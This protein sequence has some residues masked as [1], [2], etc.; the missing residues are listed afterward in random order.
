MSLLNNTAL[1]LFTGACVLESVYK[2]ISTHCCVT[3]DVLLLRFNDCC[4]ITAV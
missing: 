3:T 2:L 1:A 4:L